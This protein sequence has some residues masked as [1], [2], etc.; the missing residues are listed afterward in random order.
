MYILIVLILLLLFELRQYSPY[1]TFLVG[2]CHN[3]RCE[4]YHVHRQHKNPKDAAKLLGEITRRNEILIEHLKGKYLDNAVKNGIDPSKSNRVDVI[5]G[6]ELYSNPAFVALGDISTK[7]FLQ[8]RVRQLVNNYDTDKIYEISPLNKT[9]STSYVEN[10]RKLVLCLREKDG[11]QKL[12]DINTLY[13]VQLHEL[14]HMLNNRYQHT[15]E[16]N[17]WPLFKL[18]LQNAVEL[19]L[20]KPV[21]YSK[22]P[23]LYCGR[24]E[25][26]YNPLFDKNL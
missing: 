6:T 5:N 14:C 11:D 13:F 17:F 15:P 1:N 16:S 22:H 18:L 12:H 2:T 23:V 25:L 21:D 26:T 3:N 9:G 20:Y 7:E 19:G 8:E 4:K 24:I 10:K